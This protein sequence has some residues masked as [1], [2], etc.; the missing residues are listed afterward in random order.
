VR[1]FNFLT[2]ETEFKKQE[3]RWYQESIFRGLK[4]MDLTWRKEFAYKNRMVEQ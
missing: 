4:G 1:K 2:Q 3:R